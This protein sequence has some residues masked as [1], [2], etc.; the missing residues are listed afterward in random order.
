MN[1]SP[2]ELR[3]TRVQ[4]EYLRR[5]DASVHQGINDRT[6]LILSA[7][8]MFMWRHGGDGEFFLVPSPKG[9][10]ALAKFYARRKR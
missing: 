5:H 7:R 6:E 1:W 10:A 3:L 9:E 4:A 8:R 2:R